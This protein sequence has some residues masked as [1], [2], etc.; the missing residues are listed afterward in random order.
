MSETDKFLQALRSR[1]D[2]VYN[3]L[4]DEGLYGAMSNYTGQSH[5]G[6]AVKSDLLKDTLFGAGTGAATTALIL[7]ALG[8]AMQPGALRTG[9]LYG[10]GTGAALSALSSIAKYYLGKGASNFGQGDEV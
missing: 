4:D 5:V 2:R 9:A 7:P 8:I 3:A 1:H 10:V 6:D